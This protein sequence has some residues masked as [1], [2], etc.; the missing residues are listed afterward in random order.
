[1]V[2][3]CCHAKCVFSFLQHVFKKIVT[4]PLW[5]LTKFPSTQLCF[6][7]LTTFFSKKPFLSDIR[8]LMKIITVKQANYIVP[9]TE[10]LLLYIKRVQSLKSTI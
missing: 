3:P 10:S 8:S 6:V 2:T 9:N 1:M 4:N 5:L 7:F